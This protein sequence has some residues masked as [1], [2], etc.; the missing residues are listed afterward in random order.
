LRALAL[1]PLVLV[2][3]GCPQQVSSPAKPFEA[4]GQEDAAAVV[5]DFF[6]SYVAT[7]IAGVL[8]RIC[9]QDD[10]YR[11]AVADFV[12]RSQ[13]AG[14]RFGVERFEVRNSTPMWD[15]SAPYFLVEVAFPRASGAAAGLHA[16]RVRPKEACVE[17]LL[18]E[19]APRP[20]SHEATPVGPEPSA[21]V[22]ERAG[23]IKL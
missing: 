3:L 1:L 17:R 5:R 8:A 10:A 12:R 4:A 23:I 13:A 16:Y 6:S 2:A 20:P 9:E 7:D 19:G 11:V 14:G 22:D 15:K 21:P 18:G